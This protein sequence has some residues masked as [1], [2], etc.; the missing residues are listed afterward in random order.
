MKVPDIP[1]LA[2]SPRDAFYAQTEFVSFQESTGRIIA[3]FIMVYPPGIPILSP[4]E[5]ITQENLDYV[6]E[7]MAAGL[8]VQGPEDQTLAFLKV[9]KEQSAIV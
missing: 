2:L 5:L 7:N 1:T 6:K 4:G 8:P 3:E 9:I